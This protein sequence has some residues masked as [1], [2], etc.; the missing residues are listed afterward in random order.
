M[1]SAFAALAESALHQL[2]ADEDMLS[3]LRDYWYKSENI[4]VP[5][6]MIRTGSPHACDGDCPQ[7][8]EREHGM[9]MPIILVKGA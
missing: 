9:Y 7:D 5:N 4:P 8:C 6:L 3:F 1:A 2:D